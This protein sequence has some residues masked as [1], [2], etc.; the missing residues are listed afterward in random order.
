MTWRYKRNENGTIPIAAGKVNS[1]AGKYYLQPDKET[2][3]SMIDFQ[4]IANIL[5]L[6]NIRY[7]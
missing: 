1:L 5:C 7:E 3:R 6:E 2:I 4:A